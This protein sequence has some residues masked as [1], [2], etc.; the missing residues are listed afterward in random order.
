MRTW[1]ILSIGLLMTSFFVNAQKVSQTFETTIV[2]NFDGL[3]CDG[4]NGLCSL[5]GAEKQL[6]NGILLYDEKNTE[7][8]L[9]IDLSKLSNSQVIQLL[10]QNIEEARQQTDTA[11]EI[12]N[13]IDLTPQL[14]SLLHISDAS[15][16]I[17]EGISPA[18]ISESH[19]II[20]LTL[21]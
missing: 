15:L 13:Q 3:H 16:R 1:L 7:L 11:V 8:S 10:G 20:R 9:K 14:R 17:A 19:I 18:I 2:A 21:Q 12:S 5:E 6:S 4:K